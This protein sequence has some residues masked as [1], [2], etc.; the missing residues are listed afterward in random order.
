MKSSIIRSAAEQFRRFIRD[1]RGN[2]A[3]AF[4]VTALPAII[5]GGAGIDYSR[6]VDSRARAQSAVDAAVLRL[7]QQDSLNATEAAKTFAAST[8]LTVVS[9]SFT[10]RTN[11]AGQTVYVGDASVRVAMTFGRVL[12]LANT[13]VT[14]HSEATPPA[15]QVLTARFKPTNVQ[16]AYSKDIFIWTKDTKGALTKQTVI[17]YR[18]SSA[19]GVKT[20][21]PPVGSA[22]TTFTVPPYSTFGVGM[23]V[24]E[25][26]LS[27]SGALINPVTKY[28][29]AADASTWI[30]TSGDCS[31]GSGQTVQM[32]D[33]GDSN[34]LDLDY[35]MY[36]S[37]GRPAGAVARLTN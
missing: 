5:L 4:S 12:G 21:T 30:R 19:T 14:V 11:A 35:V 2:V 34:F 6:L 27:Y 10:T 7:A 22:S 3:I 13:A 36:C 25:D 18:Y 8:N 28:S 15:P 37:M 33:G 29:D 31:D 24:Y 23:V 17:T 20:T 1:Q 9:T 26:W 16:G 32:E